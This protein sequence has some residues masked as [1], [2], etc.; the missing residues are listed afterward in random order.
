MPV[1]VQKI[2]KPLNTSDHARI[3]LLSGIEQSVQHLLDKLRGSALS[4]AEIGEAFKAGAT[5]LAGLK[6]EPDLREILLVL[7]QAA[8]P[9]AREAIKEGSDA[10][11]QALTNAVRRGSIRMAVFD[12]QAYFWT[13][14]ESPQ[15]ALR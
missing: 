3:S 11:D 15:G 6:V 8:F 13:E 12:L 14:T 1:D 4:R 7:A 5:N 2:L 10:L 9:I